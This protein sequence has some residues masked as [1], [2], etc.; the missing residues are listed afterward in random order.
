MSFYT[1]SIT[2]KL[3]LIQ[4]APRALVFLTVHW[5]GPERHARQA[6]RAASIQ[7]AQVFPHLGIHFFTLDE[8]DSESL[9]WLT[10]LN[11]PHFGG[12]CPRGAGGLLWLERGLVISSEIT[13]NSLGTDGILARTL[14]LWHRSK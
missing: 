4:E 12:E 1:G 11:V 10:S 13:A 5:S 6:F 2:D 8:D 3:S 9:A 14:S 7:L